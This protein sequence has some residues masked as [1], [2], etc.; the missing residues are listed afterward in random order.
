MASSSPGH[1]PLTVPPSSGHSAT[2]IVPHKSS[3]GPVLTTP[4]V[5]KIAK[6]H[7][8]DL[9]TLR[10]TGPKGRIL[11]EDVL[12]YL[13]HGTPP[14]P[15]SIKTPQSTVSPTHLPASVP[16][17]GASKVSGAKTTVVPIRGIQRVMVKSMAAS[18]QVPHLGYCE[19][20]VMDSLIG[21][22]KELKK[23]L[24]RKGGSGPHVKLSYMPFIL[25]VCLPL[26]LLSHHPRLLLSHSWSI[27]WSTRQS[28][29]TAQRSRSTTTTTSASRWTLPKDSLFLF[30]RRSLTHNDLLPQ[31]GQV[32]NMSVV[33]IARELSQLQVLSTSLSLSLSLGA[34]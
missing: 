23:A 20:I 4:A 11:K 24:E 25:K 29:A 26:C 16:A 22:R 6:E 19:E 33:D 28:I 31:F 17:A 8:I 12:N 10:G 1:T 14:A 18:L 5:R 34:H 7:A 30:S 3:G 27:L 9:Q 15:S 32:Q 2:P 21:L 13:Q